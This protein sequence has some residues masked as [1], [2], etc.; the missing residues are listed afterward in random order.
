ML[1]S[2]Y[3]TDL[4]DNSLD[5]VESTAHHPGSWSVAGIVSATMPLLN[6]TDLTVATFHQSAA[7]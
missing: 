4:A 5:G 2:I 6:N 7:C 1:S 3:S